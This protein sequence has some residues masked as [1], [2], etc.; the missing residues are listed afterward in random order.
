[1]RASG[2][3]L[4]GKAGLAEGDGAMGAG[5]GID[6]DKSV[7]PVRERE[8]GKA[9]ARLEWAERLGEGLLLP[10]LLF[11]ISISFS[12]RFLLFEFKSNQIANSNLRDSSICINSCLS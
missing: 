7:P 6:S 10:F 5:E 9:G 4:T 2:A 11:R 8:R 1:V 3:T 12:F